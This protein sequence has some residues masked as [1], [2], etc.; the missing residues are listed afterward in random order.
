L[1]KYGSDMNPNRPNNSDDLFDQLLD[2]HLGAISDEDKSQ[3]EQ[4]LNS[5]PHAREINEQVKST[6]APLSTYDVPVPSGLKEKIISSARIPKLTVDSLLED[7][8]PDFT[9]PRR[10]IFS[11]FAD[12]AATAAAI[13]LISSAVLLS[14]GY[15]RQQA[16]KAFC[17]GN[18]GILGSAITSYANDFHNQLPYAKVPVNATWYDPQSKQPRRIHLFV[19]VKKNYVSPQFLI[20]PEE[21]SGGE[22]S[23]VRELS[24]LD[25]FPKDWIVS[26]SFQNLFGDQKFSPKLRQLRWTQAQQM[27][28]MADRTPLL[29][30]DQ[31]HRS[32]DSEKAFSPNHS[33]LRG[34]NILSLDGRVTW[35]KTPLFG[36]QQD[37]I[38]QAGTIRQYVGKEIPADP[39]DS[40]LAP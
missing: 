7:L 38:W 8:T 35:Q 3:I 40:F 28:V 39:T 24:S 32:I 27:A 20:C 30:K 34:Q 36:P 33:G 13:V 11:R 29:A 10:T 15:A 18:L 4:L 9:V 22:S 16:R 37:N 26:Y 23:P 2:Y 12:F 1:G 31:L 25:D 19:L 6:L 17:A 14:S 5:D 21:K